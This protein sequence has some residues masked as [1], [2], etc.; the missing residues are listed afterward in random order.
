MIYPKDTLIHVGLTPIEADIYLLMANGT[1][2][3]KKIIQQTSYKRA[4]VYYALT[5]L[6]HRGLISKKNNHLDH[7]YIVESFDVLQGMAEAKKIESEKIAEG[8]K[9]TILTFVKN[10]Q[11]K[12][13]KPTVAF[14]EGLETVK[15]IIFS[16]AYCKE[17]SIRTII[18]ADSLFWNIDETFI[19]E[20]VG[21]RI[22]NGV[23]TQSMW[24]KQ[25]DPETFKKQYK[26]ISNIR[27][28][29][30]HMS[31]MFS[32]S[33]FIYDNKVMY[34]SSLENSYC[35]VVTSLEHMKMMTALFE[36]LWINSKEYIQ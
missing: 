31:N 10:T 21:R 19:R 33:I 20:Y 23:K 25:I 3:A 36:G 27:M 30:E 22:Q 26:N 35:I 18:P 28:L 34:I 9:N 5:N 6:E 1:C 4:T 17:K 11:D 2:S 16:T 12:E 24:E 32:T 29:P 8:I 15:N 7:E 14:Y 13:G